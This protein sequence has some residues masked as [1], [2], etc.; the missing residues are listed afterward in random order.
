MKGISIQNLVC[1]ILEGLEDDTEA[2]LI[3]LDK[4][5]TFNRIDYQFLVMVLETARFKSEFC[6]WIS[7]IC[8]NLQVNGNHLETFTIECSVRQNCPLSSLLYVL[9]LD[10][11]LCRLKD[12]TA[13]P[14]LC[15][16]PFTNCV[17][18]K[19][20]VYADDICLCVPLT[21][22]TGCK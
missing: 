10:P 12:E 14:A 17:R 3:N 4:S 6:K 8:H 21:R 1:K 22:H 5:K 18:A 15:G 7:M 20:S 19:V 13:N 16:V 2:M 11:L 9:A